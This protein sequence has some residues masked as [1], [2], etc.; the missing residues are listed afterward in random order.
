VRTTGAGQSARLLLDVAGV[1]VREAIDYA[2]VGAMAASVHG[3]IR[4]SLDAD[5]VVGLTARRLGMLADRFRAL[6]FKTEFRRGDPADPVPALLM[7][8]DPFG[9][10]VDLLV[11]LRGMSAAAF[12][13]AIEV[14]FQGETLRVIGREDFIAM[15]L[16][17]GG[18]IDIEDARRTIAAAGGSLDWTLLRHLTEGYGSDAV[19]RLEGLP[20]ASPT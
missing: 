8:S 15:K 17:A 2:V 9:N 4:A 3:V 1:L 16:F 7:L 6:G 5:A 13:R 10:R 19:A 20:G 18:P 11:T 12:S 14:P